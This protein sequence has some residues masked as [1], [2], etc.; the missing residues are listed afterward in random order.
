MYESSIFYMGMI[1]H[2]LGCWTVC[3]GDG[4]CNACATIPCGRAGVCL[5]PPSPPQCTIEI[6]ATLL[7]AQV[8]IL[9]LRSLNG[10]VKQLQT[11]IPWQIICHTRLAHTQHP[12]FLRTKG[13]VCGELSDH[14]NQ[15][16]HCDVKIQH[17][18]N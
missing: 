13:G 2:N 16:L 17:I 6:C 5:S 11:N 14:S 12:E 9:L 15:W 8:S 18:L 7:L 1:S 10:Q 3:A 4:P